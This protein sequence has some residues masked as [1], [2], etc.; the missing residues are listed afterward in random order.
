[1]AARGSELD[2]EALSEATQTLAAQLLEQREPARALTLLREAGEQAPDDVALWTQALAAARAAGDEEQQQEILSRLIEA[3]S[4]RVKQSSWLNEA[5]EVAKKRGQPELAT[6]ILKR[7]LGVDPED[8]QALNRLEAECEVREDWAQLVELLGR[9]LAL[10]VSVRER[11]RLVLWRSE[12]FETRLGLLAEARQELSTLVEQAPGDRS[13]IE[14]FAQLSE[15]LGDH[16]GAAGAWLTA[17]GLSSTRP[18]AAQLAE[19]S[20]RLYLDAGD[21]LS[22]RRVLAAP[23]TVPRSLGLARLAVRLERDGQND[24]RLAR[25]LEELAQVT[26]QPIRERASAQ[27]EAANIWRRLGDDERA[28]QCAN[29]A[30]NWI[31]EDTEAQILASYLEY[32]RRGPRGQA[33]ARASVQRLRPVL[34]SAT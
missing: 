5:W 15:A 33:E 25:A 4:D 28:C 23:Q 1:R 22:A 17:S 16:A 13:V 12:L 21:V 19:R 31:P 14:R 20:C 18:V 3:S 27:L 34:A 2:R 9:H 10:G 26:D 30:A 7:W 29:E 8:T 32:R 24:P 11:R 6:E